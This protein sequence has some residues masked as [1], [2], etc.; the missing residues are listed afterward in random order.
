MM[1]FWLH[2]STWLR[3]AAQRPFDV[4]IS[5]LPSYAAEEGDADEEGTPLE[6]FTAAACGR[7]L[8]C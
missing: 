6:T 4:V 2:S 3:G 5:V 8:D 7:D 1:E